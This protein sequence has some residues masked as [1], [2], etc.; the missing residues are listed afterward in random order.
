[1]RTAA[2]RKMLEDSHIISSVNFAFGGRVLYD[3]RSNL[4]RPETIGLLMASIMERYCKFLF[5]PKAD[6]TPEKFVETYM[7]AYKDIGVYGLLSNVFDGRLDQQLATVIPDSRLWRVKL[8]PHYGKDRARLE[9]LVADFE[10]GLK[11]AAAELHNNEEKR[12]AALSWFRSHPVE[13][14]YRGDWYSDDEVHEIS[15]YYIPKIKTALDSVPRIST[16][17]GLNFG[18]KGYL[19]NITFDGCFGRKE[20]KVPVELFIALMKLK[21]VSEVL[22]WN[23]NKPNTPAKK[24]NT[25]SGCKI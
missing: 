25:K 3:I 17:V 6:K 18:D 4:S 19:I 8:N 24:N 5:T 15:E 23:D 1:M 7:P 13:L 14:L 9:T 22:G 20:A 10:R 11:L 16:A 21:P 12:Q 2:K